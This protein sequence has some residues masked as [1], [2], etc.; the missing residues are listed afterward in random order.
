MRDR[1]ARSWALTRQSWGV[2]MQDKHLMVFPIISGLLSLV[3]IA[4]G[5]APLIA[6][7][8]TRQGKQ[9]DE[10]IKRLFQGPVAYGVL[11]GVYFVTFTIITYFNAALAACVISRFNGGDSSASAGLRAAT[12]RLP[13][14]LA[15]AAVNA[16]VGVVLQVLK[17]RAGWIARLLLGGVE[18][19]WGIATF[20]VV[21]VLVVEDVGPIDAVKRSVEVLKK[22]WGE[23]LIAQFGT[24]IVLTLIGAGFLIGGVGGGIAI[25]VAMG[26]PWVGLAVG[27]VGLAG[28]VLTALVSTTLRS[29]MVVAC[30]RYAATGEAPGAFDGAML[31]GMFRVK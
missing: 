6:Y 13:K 9:T 4:A 5:A 22:T 8:A 7:A 2:L 31:K 20:F 26:T 12:R 17:E 24:S 11:F 16:T 14:I 27:A 29:I 28:A 10:E 21:P 23:S 1:M 25:A 15:W 19:M 3:V 30:Y 18:L